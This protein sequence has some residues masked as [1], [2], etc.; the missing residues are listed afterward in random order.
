MNTN[1][2]QKMLFLTQFLIQ[3]NACR[4]AV[5]DA[6]PQIHLLQLVVPHNLNLYLEVE[7]EILNIKSSLGKSLNHNDIKFILYMDNTPV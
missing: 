1:K 7:N 6:S 4:L 5:A 2:S 3:D